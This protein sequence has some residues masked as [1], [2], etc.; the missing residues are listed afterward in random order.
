MPTALQIAQGRQIPLSAGLLMAL[1]AD[2]PALAAIDARTSRSTK[3]LSMAITSLPTA[4]PFINYGEGFTA[5]EGAMELR[6][7]D[8]SLVGGQIKAERIAAMKWDAEHGAAGYTWF[9]LQ[10][11][12]KMK[13]QGLA[14]EA[15]IFKGT[16]ADAKG[17]PGFKELTPFL[18]ANIQTLT[19]TSASFQFARSVINAAGSA[20]G[21]ASS[22]YAVIEG[23]MDVQLVLGEDMDPSGDFFRLSEMVVS[24]EAPNPAEATK[25]SLHDLQQFSGHIGLSIGGFNQTPGSVVPTQYSVRRLANLTTDTAAKLSDAMMD[26]LA[27]SFGSTKRPTKF[28]MASRSGEYLAASRSATAVNYFMGQ[29]G[30]A[31]RASANIYPEPPD[32]WRGIPIIYADNSIGE[33]DAVEVAA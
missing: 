25:R 5:T 4:G 22:V 14:L 19:Q 11:M 24:N 8:C 1:N 18:T 15:Q 28:F 27:R 20:A 12:L 26:K 13:A 16:V 23:E 21:T 2:A 9:D 31:A 30:D 29:S 7:F 17:F 3:F 10:T 6:E 32:N 33:S